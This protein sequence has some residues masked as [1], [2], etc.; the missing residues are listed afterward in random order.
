MTAISVSDKTKDEFDELKPDDY[1]HDEFVSELMQVYK[2]QDTELA[3][4]TIVD[5]LTDEI[6]DSVA[7]EAELASY[8]GTKDA[9]ES[10]IIE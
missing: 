2:T 6:G 3:I 1:T 10:T 8:R 7:T 5:Q 9:I 4:E